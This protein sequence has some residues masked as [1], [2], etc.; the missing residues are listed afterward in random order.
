MFTGNV[1]RWQLDRSSVRLLKEVD[2]TT[3]P[4]FLM[5]LSSGIKEGRGGGRRVTGLLLN[6]VTGTP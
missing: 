3:R 4:I 1:V 2:S 5:E 6:V